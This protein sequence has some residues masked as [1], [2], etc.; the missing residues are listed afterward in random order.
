MWRLHDDAPKSG[1]TKSIL[2]VLHDIPLVTPEQMRFWEWMADYYMCT[3]GEVMR[4]ALPATVKPHARTEEEFAAYSPRREKVL[5]LDESVLAG[6]IEE[7]MRR[8]AGPE[9]ATP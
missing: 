3:V 4:M 2:R 8:R 9:T 5:T 7:R 1:R 6:E